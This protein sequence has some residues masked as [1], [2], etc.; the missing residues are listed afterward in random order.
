MSKDTTDITHLLPEMSEREA[1]GLKFIA[2]LNRKGGHI[3]GG[4]ANPKA[5]AKRRAKN[6]VAKRSRRA[7]RP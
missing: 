1:T 7:N 6:K 2:A 5:V 4:T 3:Y